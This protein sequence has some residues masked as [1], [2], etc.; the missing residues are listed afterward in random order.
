MSK[1]AP[2]QTRDQRQEDEL[3]ALRAIYAE[4][5]HDVPPKKTAWG[6]AAEEGWWEVRVKGEDERVQ[7][8]IK[9]RMT[10]VSVVLGVSSEE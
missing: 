10:K 4:D 3:Q 1:S 6:T 7:V 9:G 5:W 2:A 8:G